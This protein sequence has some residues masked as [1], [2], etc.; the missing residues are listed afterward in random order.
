MCIYFNVCFRRA[1]EARSLD[2]GSSVVVGDDHRNMEIPYG[3]DARGEAWGTHNRHERHVS[4][5]IVTG[6]TSESRS[7]AEVSPED[8]EDPNCSRALWGRHDMG[9][10]RNAAGR[11][12]M[13]LIMSPLTLIA[14]TLIMSP[15]TFTPSLAL[16]SGAPCPSPGTCDVVGRFCHGVAPPEGPPYSSTTHLSPSSYQCSYS[17]HPSLPP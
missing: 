12:A 11:I 15:L 3:E 14:M 1:K 8:P 6:H 9:A 16:L 17:L 5:T 7:A 2:C 4:H 10:R 13:T